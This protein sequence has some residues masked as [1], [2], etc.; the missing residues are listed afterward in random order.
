MLD[1]AESVKYKTEVKIVSINSFI[2][3]ACD[4]KSIQR[5]T[6]WLKKVEPWACAREV[7]V[8]GKTHY[9]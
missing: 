8:K 9:K 5:K 4:V 3:G 6:I 1:M 7:L 2:V